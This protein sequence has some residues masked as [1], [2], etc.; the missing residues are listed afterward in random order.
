[1]G[2]SSFRSLGQSSRLTHLFCPLGCSVNTAFADAFTRVFIDSDDI[3]V[4]NKANR[5]LNEDYNNNQNASKISRDR[6]HRETDY[7]DLAY[8]RWTKSVIS[9]HNNNVGRQ[10]RSN[11]QID[12][13]LTGHKLTD[14]HQLCHRSLVEQFRDDADATGCRGRVSLR[15]AGINCSTLAS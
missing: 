14:F 2:L 12:I 8:I 11:T 1:M 6:P 4:L 15:L 7:K 9:L 5:I 13:L 10:V 3:Q